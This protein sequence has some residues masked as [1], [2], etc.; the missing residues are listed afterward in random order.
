[1]SQLEHIPP[2]QMPEVL[3]AATRLY[4]ADREA[5]QERKSAVDAAAELDIPEE[6]LERAA[7]LVRERRAQA[8]IQRRNRT[9]VIVGTVAAV[10]V[11]G[12]GWTLTHRPAPPPTTFSFSA[13][14]D[15]QWTANISAGSTVTVTFPQVAGHG[16]VANVHVDHF[17]LLPSGEYYINFD[18]HAV[19]SSLSGYKTVTFSAR[20]D[21]ISHVK[22]V[23]ENGD[24]RWRS[25]LLNVSSGWR[26][27]QLPLSQ[28]EHQVRANSTA[29]WRNDGTSAPSTAGRISFKLGQNVNDPTTTGD[30]QIDRITLK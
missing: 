9:R 29:S 6:Y 28:L 5:N 23:F 22:V 8:V 12:V 27:Y 18:T 25:T 20:G 4:D 30:L 14:S 11:I 19:P 16:T 1:M 2:E 26:E 15:Q 13:N 3:A 24:E 21:G 10:A 17:Q 7:V